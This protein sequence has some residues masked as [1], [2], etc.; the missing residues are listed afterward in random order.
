IYGKLS[1]L[2]GR[3]PILLVGFGFF[4][5]GSFLCGIAPTTGFLIG[6][7]AVQGLGAASL[8]TTTLAVI[9]DLFPPAERGKYM[10]LIGAVMGISSVVGPL[11]GGII[12]DLVGWHWVFFINLPVGAVATWLIV[13]HMPRLGGRADR[14]TRIDIAGAFWLVA[15]VVPFLV[16][17]SLG[18]GESSPVGEG[19]AWT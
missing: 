9:A 13:T 11:A 3:K 18:R 4:M 14:S 1:D 15:A 7:R 17:L 19:L 5:L 16:A 12:T 8:F 6:A 2:F 10:G